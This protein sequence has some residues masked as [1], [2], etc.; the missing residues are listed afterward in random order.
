MAFWQ[1]STI[2]KTKMVPS[3]K[4]DSLVTPWLQHTGTGERLAAGFSDISACL[5]S[6]TLS[7]DEALKAIVPI[8][9]CQILE[10]ESLWGNRRGTEGLGGCVRPRET[11]HDFC[12]HALDVPPLPPEGT[13]CEGITAVAGHLLGSWE[14][15]N[16]IKRLGFVTI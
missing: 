4:D 14:D 12:C 16:I 15:Y 11:Q 13:H 9:Y 10:A 1:E 8:L 2:T 6:C 7:T 5:R 3:L